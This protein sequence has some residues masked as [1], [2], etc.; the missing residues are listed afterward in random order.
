[1]DLVNKGEPKYVYP[2]VGNPVKKGL[3][4]SNKTVPKV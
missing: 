3:I 2:V 1:M 4:S